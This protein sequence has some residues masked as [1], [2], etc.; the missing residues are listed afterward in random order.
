MG[1]ATPALTL[2]DTDPVGPGTVLTFGGAGLDGKDTNV[3]PFPLP[4]LGS[5]ADAEA[6]CV[7]RGCS[8]I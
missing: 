3:W 2:T 4:I 7:Y 5:D 6:D 1:I 8:V